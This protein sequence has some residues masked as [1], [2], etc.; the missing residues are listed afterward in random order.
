MPFSRSRSPESITRSVT[1]EPIRKAPDCQSMA[2][3]RVVLPWS[4]C[5]TMA[6]LRRSLRVDR[7][8]DTAVHPS[9]GR[10][11]SLSARRRTRIASARS[12]KGDPSGR[13]PASRVLGRT[14][15]D[16]ARARPGQ[17]R[18][19]R[20]SRPGWSYTG[21]GPPPRRLKR[22]SGRRRAD[23]ESDRWRAQPQRS[24]RRLEPPRR[25]TGSDRTRSPPAGGHRS[26][27]HAQHERVGHP[28]DELVHLR[29]IRPAS[30][31][32]IAIFVRQRIGVDPAA[33]DED[34]G[35]EQTLLADYRCSTGIRVVRPPAR[36]WRP[37]RHG[38]PSRQTWAR[39]RRRRE[40]R[41]RHETCRRRRSGTSSPICRPSRVTVND[42]PCSTASMI[43]FD[44]IR[45]SR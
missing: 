10:R 27:G 2:S 32:L 18:P 44:R 5:A 30:T 24:G 21:E 38:T 45:R 37:D 7:S 4:T 20:R 28:L 41:T 17:C 12:S 22:S 39:T 3:T 34:V 14:H 11:P 35:V 1:A 31:A 36:R 42:W 26:D 43:S 9:V 25:R 6:T 8:W 33:Q 40:L 13:R 16:A 29:T 23:A 19:S 15:P